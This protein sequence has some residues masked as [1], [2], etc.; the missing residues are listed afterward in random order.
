MIL[1]VYE[2]SVHELAVIWPKYSK[3]HHFINN[4]PVSYMTQLCKQLGCIMPPSW[5]WTVLN[6]INL[7]IRINRDRDAG[8]GDA[9]G[10]SAPPAF[11]YG[12]KGGQ[13]CPSLSVFILYLLMYFSLKIQLKALNVQS[14]QKF[15]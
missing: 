5:E 15:I 3:V 13:K 10:V 6:N 4:H 9:R 11:S 1:A 2:S 8:E 12:G 14:W 7:G